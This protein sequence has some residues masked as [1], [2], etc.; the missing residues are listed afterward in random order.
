MCVTLAQSSRALVLGREF[1]PRNQAATNSVHIRTERTFSSSRPRRFIR[2]PRLPLLAETYAAPIRLPTLLLMHRSPGRPSGARAAEDRN[3]RRPTGPDLG[4]TRSSGCLPGNLDIETLSRTYHSIKRFV[5]VVPLMALRADL[6]RTPPT[7]SPVTHVR[8]LRPAEP[9]RAAP[10]CRERSVLPSLLL[11]SLGA[12]AFSLSGFPLSSGQRLP[13][14]RFPASARR[15]RTTEAVRASDPCSA[16]P[17]HL[18]PD[19]PT[20][21]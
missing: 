11:L 20:S 12:S 16:D 9:P 15:T 10:A 8:V 1:T 14:G 17:A 4:S 21:R 19:P 5:R 7:L 18:A 3:G 13:S 2:T 6:T